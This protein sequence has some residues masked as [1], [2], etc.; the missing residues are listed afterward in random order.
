L[1]VYLTLVI[2]TWFLAPF[3]CRLALRSSGTAEP[4]DA[5]SANDLNWGEIMIF[6]TGI[7]VAC[8]GISRL[9]D[10]V[11]PILQSHSSNLPHELNLA[12][13]LSFFIALGLIGVGGLLAVRFAV[14]YGWCQKRKARAHP[15]S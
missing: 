1:L 4:P 3:V 15:S 6:L 5:V 11:I 12:D 7:L 8:W 2:A 10:G 13:K 9:G 14:V